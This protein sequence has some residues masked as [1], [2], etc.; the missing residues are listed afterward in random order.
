MGKADH[1]VL[2]DHNATCYECGKKFKASTLKR[3]WQGY[4]VCPAH[5]EPRQTQDFVRA[6]P[7]NMSVPWAQPQPADTFGLSCTL[8]GSSSVP[9]LATPGCMIPGRHFYYSDQY[10]LFCTLATVLARA[11]FGAAG[12]ITVGKT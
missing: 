4:Y 8:D 5:W 10:P 12:C 3:H 6:V 1:L 2:G 9:G 11:G 7:D